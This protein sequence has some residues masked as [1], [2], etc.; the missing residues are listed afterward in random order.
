MKIEV[1]FFV[2]NFFINSLGELRSAGPENS[3]NHWARIGPV[4]VK[5]LGP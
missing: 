5:K 4:C 1:F 2:M 3:I